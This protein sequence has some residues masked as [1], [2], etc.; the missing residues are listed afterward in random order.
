MAAFVVCAGLFV[1]AV[2][3][4]VFGRLLVRPDFHV[5]DPLF[6]L[7][8]GAML[9]LAGVEIAARLPGQK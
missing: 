6:A 4:D 7:L 9:A 2:L 5:G 1:V 3:V 8:L